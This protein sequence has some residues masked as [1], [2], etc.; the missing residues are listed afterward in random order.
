[1]RLHLKVLVALLLLAIPSVAWAQ[2]TF[3]IQVYDAALT[4]T[5]HLETDYHLNTTWV[6]P[7]TPIGNTAT[8]HAFH[9]TMENVYGVSREVEVGL[10]LLSAWNDVGPVFAG[11]HWRVRV[12]TPPDWS[13]PVAFSLNCELAR[14][15]TAYAFGTPWSLEIRPIADYRAHR[16]IAVFNPIVDFGLSGPSR[17][18]YPD[19]EPC[20][21]LGYQIGPTW[22][23]GLEY[24]TGLGLIDHM[25]RPTLQ[26]HYIYV[27]SDI[28]LSN[29]VALNVGVGHGLTRASSE[30]VTKAIVEVVF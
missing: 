28:E 14:D 11:M 4:K 27:A 5:G 29:H 6:G 21:H 24:Y 8:V 10:Y 25:V 26:R 13:F 19:F 7:A 16:L 12:R 15:A 22:D 17:N 9:A 18:R 30:L 23:A 3:E 1:V 2:D 20:L